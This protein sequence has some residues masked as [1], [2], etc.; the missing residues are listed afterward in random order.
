MTTI[1]GLHFYELNIQVFMFGFVI[2][3]PQFSEILRKLFCRY[4]CVA[5]NLRFDFVVFIRPES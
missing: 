5:K 1:N 2:F 4:V 3:E